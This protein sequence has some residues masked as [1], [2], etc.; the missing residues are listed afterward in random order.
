[1]HFCECNKKCRK[2]GDGETI[3]KDTYMCVQQDALERRGVKSSDTSRETSV[4]VSAR[5]SVGRMM[6]KKQ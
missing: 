4:C 3:E 6:V 2:D 5:I 1:M